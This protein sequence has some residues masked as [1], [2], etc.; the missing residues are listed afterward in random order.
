MIRL[1]CVE[2]LS[3]DTL[4]LGDS[5]EKYWHEVHRVS[6]DNHGC[7]LGLDGSLGSPLIQL[8][9]QIPTYL[10]DFFASNVE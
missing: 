7:G 6:G 5:L 8:C 4:R 9:I 10:T 2:T 3:F 1:L